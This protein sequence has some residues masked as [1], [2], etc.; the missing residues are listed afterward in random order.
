VITGKG[1]AVAAGREEKPTSRLRK[2]LARSHLTSVTGD[3]AGRVGKGRRFEGSAASL[4]RRERIRNSAAR[5]RGGT[6][7]S[8]LARRS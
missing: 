6:V 1:E 5:E 3:S 2:V 8:A 4:V 7:S